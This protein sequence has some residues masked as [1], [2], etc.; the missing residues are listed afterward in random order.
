MPRVCGDTAV[1]ARRA[2]SPDARAIAAVADAS[3]AP[4]GPRAAR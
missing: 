3:R 1:T 2:G 4:A